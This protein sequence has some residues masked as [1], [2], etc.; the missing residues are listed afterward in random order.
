MFN[1]F[2]SRA[3]IRIIGILS[4]IVIALLLLSS[5]IAFS[6][7]LT[8]M[9]CVLAIFWF[10]FWVAAYVFWN[11]LVTVAIPGIQQY[12]MPNGTYQWVAN[13]CDLVSVRKPDLVGWVEEYE[14]LDSSFVNLHAGFECRYQINSF[15]PRG[16]IA[17]F[18]LT[19][20][21]RSAP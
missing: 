20:A 8:T 9:G 6:N 19:E 21:I 11:S 10:V 17:E 5:G 12:R 18:I 16:Y 15:I 4:V 3:E 2:F 14:F 13:R 7:D 1:N